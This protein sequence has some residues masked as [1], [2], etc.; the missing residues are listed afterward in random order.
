MQVGS[1]LARSV[2]SCP[3]GYESVIQDPGPKEICTDPQHWYSV[4]FSTTV[5]HFLYSTVLYSDPQH[6]LISPITQHRLYDFARIRWGAEPSSRCCW[7]RRG[8]SGL[9]GTPRTAPSA[10]TTTASSCRRPT[11]WSSGTNVHFISNISMTVSSQLCLAWRTIFFSARFIH[12]S[13]DTIR[14]CL[15]LYT[16]T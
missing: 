1:D 8:A 6:C 12:R 4:L 10:I 7:T 5:L 9:S 13:I 16:L 15:P 14:I 11:R 2:I 3:P